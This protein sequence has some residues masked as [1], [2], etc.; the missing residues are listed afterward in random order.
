MKGVAVFLFAV[1]SVNVSAQKYQGGIVDKTVAVIGNEV[2]MIS[3]K[4]DT[5]R[6]DECATRFGYRHRRRCYTH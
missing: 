5:P 4:R 1:V 3:D 2:V 6:R